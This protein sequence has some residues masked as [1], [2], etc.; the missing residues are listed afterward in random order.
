MEPVTP[1]RICAVIPVLNEAGAIGPMLKRL[2]TV[3]DVAIV[4]DGGSS[5]TTVAEA[6]EAGAIVL[7]ETRRGYGQ[8][9]QTGADYAETLGAE[10]VV[11]MDGD[12]ADSVENTSRLTAPVLQ[13][14]A[15]FV[16]ADRS[17]GERDPGSMGL[18]QIL[19][20]HLIGAAVGVIA[21]KRYRDMCA[22]RAIRVA[23]L[24]QLGMREMGYGWNLEMQIRAARAGLRVLEVPMP[25]HNR[26]AGQSKVAGSLKG[27][28]RAGQRIV[29]TLVS[30]GLTARKRMPERVMDRSRL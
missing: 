27:S 17:A 23:D 15:D 25:Y 11:F 4:V 14:Q 22:F 12:G 29:R 10:L 3:I 28:L 26:I 1:P 24:K 8:A 6:R 21:G 20:G 16:L 2:P 13:G 18:H 30:V 19:A 7:H 5:D 9:C